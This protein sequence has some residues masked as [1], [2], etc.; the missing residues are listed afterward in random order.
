MMENFDV[1]ETKLENIIAATCNILERNKEAGDDLAAI[2]Q[3]LKKR[4]QQLQ[5]LYQSKINKERLTENQ[6][7]ILRSFFTRFYVLEKKMNS[8]FEDLSLYYEQSL[9]NLKKHKKANQAYNTGPATSTF[10][11]T[12]ISG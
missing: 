2:D 7:D 4:E 11:N 6:K 3:L 10:L 1:I 12:K 9:R 5:A 8:I